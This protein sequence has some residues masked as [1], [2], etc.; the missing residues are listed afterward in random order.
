MLLA[1]GETDPKPLKPA[2][3]VG[4]GGTVEQAA[5]KTLF[6]IRACRKSVINRPFRGWGW[7]L[8]FFRSL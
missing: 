5:E 1:R 4:L 7:H 8:D 3:I 2:S 6:R